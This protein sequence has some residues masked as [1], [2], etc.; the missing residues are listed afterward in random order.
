MKRALPQY[1]G[2]VSSAQTTLASYRRQEMVRKVSPAW[3][4]DDE[5]ES[6][7]EI[8]GQQDLDIHQIYRDLGLGDGSN[9]DRHRDPVFEISEC[10]Y[11]Y[12][13]HAYPTHLPKFAERLELIKELQKRTKALL[14]GFENTSENSFCDIEESITRGLGQEPSAD[15]PSE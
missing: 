3:N 12:Q 4:W 14:E 11:Q 5:G 9:I 1:W 7:F 2:L 6:D 13:N 10:L 8:E 15:M